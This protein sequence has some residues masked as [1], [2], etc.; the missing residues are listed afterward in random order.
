MCDAEHLMVVFT[1]AAAGREDEFNEWYDTVHIP[2][3]TAAMGITTVTRY[4]AGER[5]DIDPRPAPPFRYLALYDLGDDPLGALTRLAQVRPTLTP[6]DALDE[7]RV[8][9][10]YRKRPSRP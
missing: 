7:E 4:E 3:V 5:P 1:N 2:E 10:I 8:S 9:L 6:S